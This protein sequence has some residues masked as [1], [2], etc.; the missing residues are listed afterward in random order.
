SATPPFEVVDFERLETSVAR[1][2]LP[3]FV[4]PAKGCF[5]VL[6]RA[7]ATRDELSAFLRDPLVADYRGRY[8]AIYRRLV[9]RYL[10][11]DVDGTAF[12]VEGLLRG[13]LVTVE[14]FATDTEVVPLGV[15]DSVTDPQHGSFVAF[16]Y[17]SALPAEVQRRLEAVTARLGAAFGLCWTMFNVEL[18]W[19]AATDRISIIELNAR[20][21]GQFADLYE[22]VDG[23][24][25]HRL[26]L[27]LACGRRPAFRRGSG[28]CAVAASYPLRVFEPVR[29]VHAPD[30]GELAAAVA[31]LPEAMAWNEVATGDR[32]TDFASCDDGKS[33]RYAVL[34]VG[35]DSRD[36]LQQARDTFVAAAGYRFE[37][38][39]P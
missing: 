39:V 11:A 3:G 21:C 15:V 32:L 19:D 36:G 4:K 13:R 34:N 16:E 29:V 26:A 17:P 20:M 5:S 14:A 10:G 24:H 37:R 6:A 27:E 28:P 7:V 18:M 23:V 30:P 2:P 12:V 33:Y 22:K 25:G 31:R 35:A 38:L 8:L 9:E 1:A